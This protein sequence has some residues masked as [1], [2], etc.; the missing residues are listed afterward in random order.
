MTNPTIEQKAEM[1]LANVT[2]GLKDYFAHT[3]DRDILDDVSF[4]FKSKVARDNA[5]SKDRLREMFRKH[6]GWNEE[7]D[8]VV[9]KESMIKDPDKTEICNLI[10]EIFDLKYSFWGGREMPVTNGEYALLKSF[11][12]GYDISD[13]ETTELEALF[14]RLSPKAYAKGKKKSKIF[15]QLAL[16]LDL[17]DESKGSKWQ[18]LFAK[19]ADEMN[20]R[21]IDFDLIIS[22]NPVHFLTM[23]NPKY[24]RRG[25]TLTSCH[26]FNSTEYTYNNG[27]SG[28][29]RDDV[30]FIVFT[31]ADPKDP[32]S[33]NNRKTGREIF[34]YDPGNG[35]LLQSRH[36]NTNG[37][38]RGQQVESKIWRDIV[39]RVICQC[40]DEPNLWKVYRATDDKVCELVETGYG[41]GGYADWEYSEFNAKIAIRNSNS[42]Y[43]KTLTVGTYGLCIRCGDD[44]DDDRG[45]YC[46]D[47]D[48]EAN[49]EYCSHCGEY[50]SADDGR[51]AVINGEEQF[52]C[53]YC[54]E[55][56]VSECDDCGELF[57]NDSV[58]SVESGNRY[59]CEDCLESHY[60]YCEE[61]NE[62]EHIDNVQYVE[63][64]ERY[65]CDDCLREYYSRCDECGEWILNEDLRMH[66]NG[67]SYCENCYEE[68]CNQ[69]D[70]ESE[71]EV[72]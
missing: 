64:T 71:S 45:L 40:E 3:S 30:S 24:D 29:A 32:A 6:P 19:L 67:N 68:I 65:V 61:C 47:C 72:A 15:R 66:E 5:R 44:L 38:T 33:Y 17:V 23:S 60:L 4:E 41:F 9:V 2:K 1:N 55:N 43:P 42:D 52:V 34:A 36:Y 37:G 12:A 8:A 21:R 11:F 50:H 69:E 35:V 57:W 7:L 27:C 53:E 28:Y 26:S 48:H 56:E 58:A 10:S 31:V 49:E 63:S 16:D 22:V 46:Y 14:K 18:Q 51:W 54:W 70:E 39:E 62:Y 13:A 20:S 59:V 25:S